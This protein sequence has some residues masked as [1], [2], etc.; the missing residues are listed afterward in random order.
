MKR[1]IHAR[2]DPEAR[3]GL[4]RLKKETGQSDSEL[5][6]RGL[7]LVAR[8]VRGRVS[9]FDLGRRSVGKFKGGPR[10]LSRNPDHFESFGE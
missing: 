4:E 8:E 9:A 6:R 5:V 7:Q 2:L 3:A 1:Y 10:D